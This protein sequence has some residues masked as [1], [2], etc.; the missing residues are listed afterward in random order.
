MGQIEEREDFAFMV[1][2]HVGTEA[3]DLREIDE[4]SRKPGPVCILWYDIQDDLHCW[5]TGIKKILQQSKSRPQ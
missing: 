5:R 4:P 1:K 3:K 2:T